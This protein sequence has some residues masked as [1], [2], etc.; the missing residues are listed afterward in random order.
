MI[1][2]RLYKESHELLEVIMKTT[3]ADVMFSKVL[4]TRINA[5]LA[6]VSKAKEAERQHIE[7]QAREEEERAA[8]RA[9][10]KQREERFEIAPALES[11]VDHGA[12]G[13]VL[14]RRGD[15]RLIWRKGCMVWQGIGMGRAYHPAEL[16]V[17]MGRHFH[18]G[19]RSV[20]RHYHEHVR[21][22]LTVALIQKHFHEID[23]LMGPGSAQAV[24]D[25][26]LEKTVVL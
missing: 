17:Q 11:G 14:L 7:R 3:N 5:H 6:V 20:T 22:V 25:G 16:E 10:R 24:I 2:Q 26:K 21:A 4:T 1:D 23:E 8:Q 18:E 9:K 15:K 12:T 13:R 19:Y